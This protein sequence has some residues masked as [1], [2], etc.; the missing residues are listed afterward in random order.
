MDLEV[1]ELFDNMH[2]NASNIDVSNIDVSNIDVNMIHKIDAAVLNP[3][4]FGMQYDVPECHWFGITVVISDI[5]TKT[6]HWYFYM[7]YSMKDLSRSIGLRPNIPETRIKNGDRYAFVI[8]HFIGIDKND[9]KFQMF[10]FYSQFTSDLDWQSIFE[11]EN[12][13]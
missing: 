6:M 11:S 2:I 7:F 5:K 4:K 1:R 13:L 3:L 10:H 8:V 9:I 12:I